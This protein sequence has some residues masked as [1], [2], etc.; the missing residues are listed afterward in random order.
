LHRERCTGVVLDEVASV[1]ELRERLV[2]CQ[3]DHAA[4]LRA[5]GIYGPVVEEELPASW[6]VP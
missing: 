5:A 3:E 4:C 2:R 1:E 6:P